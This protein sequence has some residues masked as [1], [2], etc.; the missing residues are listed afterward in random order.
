MN[1]SP[2]AGDIVTADGQTGRFKV[3]SIADNGLAQLQPFNVSKQE[4]FGKVMEKIPR[5][6]LHLFKEDASQAAARI[7]RDATEDR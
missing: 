5:K 2:K 7:V 1:Y 3:L 4:A 6:A